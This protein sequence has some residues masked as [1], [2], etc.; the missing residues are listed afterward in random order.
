MGLTYSTKSHQVK[1]IVADI[2]QLLEE[3]PEIALE[4]KPRFNKIGSF[5]LEVRVE[6]F[7][8]TIDWNT[9]LRVQEDINFAILEIVEK[10]KGKLA[11][12]TQTVELSQSN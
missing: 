3:T 9:Y 12:P 8:T 2:Q 5:A 6:Y 7:V 10:H 11:F 1:A 4:G